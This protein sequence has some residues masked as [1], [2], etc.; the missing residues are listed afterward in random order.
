MIYSFF[1]PVVKLYWRIFKPES[2]GVKVVIIHPDD[3]NLVMLVRHS[4][5]NTDLW[6][7]PGGE[8]NPKKE[9]AE[10][11]AQRE[12]I[13]ELGVKVLGL[14]YLGQYQTGGEGKR[15]T[16]TLFSGVIEN[17]E[18]IKTNSELSELEWVEM[19]TLSSRGNDVARVARRAVENFLTAR[20]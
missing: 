20:T 12:I 15:D 4:Y 1:M 3:S 13:E 11:A 18:D 19:Q 5:G 16:V 17:L 7:I 8:Y 10:A 9:T 2:F 14:E 6:N